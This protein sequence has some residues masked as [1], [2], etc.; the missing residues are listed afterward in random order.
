MPAKHTP[1]GSAQ[2]HLAGQE[3]VVR[4]NLLPLSGRRRGKINV[5]GLIKCLRLYP[6]HIHLLWKDTSGAPHARWLRRV[7]ANRGRWW[8]ACPACG[9]RTWLI[10]VIGAHLACTRCAKLTQKPQKWAYRQPKGGASW[11]AW[12]ERRARA[13]LT[14]RGRPR[15][16][17]KGE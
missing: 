9:H 14:G 2:S 3:L 11:L 17:A 6:E 7:P 1:G 12:L 15:K 4:L 5:G 13:V 16:A 10:Y 8:V